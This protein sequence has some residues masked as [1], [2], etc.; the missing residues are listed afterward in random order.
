MAVT[1]LLDTWPSVAGDDMVA[2]PPPI[3]ADAG[4]EPDG[5]PTAAYDPLDMLVTSQP[6][7]E[8][9]GALSSMGRQLRQARRRHDGDASTR[10]QRW[11]DGRLDERAGFRTDASAPCSARNDW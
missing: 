10:L 5:D 8:L 3:R 6:V 4:A 1:S 7:A 9:D 2:A 11:I